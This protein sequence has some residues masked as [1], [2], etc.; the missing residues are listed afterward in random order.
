MA[1][2]RDRKRKKWSF[3]GTRREGRIK[4]KPDKAK[5]LEGVREGSGS[6]QSPYRKQEGKAGCGGERGKRG[7]LRGPE[8]REESKGSL[9]FFHVREVFKEDT[10]RTKAEG[11]Q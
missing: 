10:L 6:R 3:M 1:W 7:P 9:I 2:S 11:R 5:G 8:G 4:V